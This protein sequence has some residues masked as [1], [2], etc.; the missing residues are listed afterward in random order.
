MADEVAERGAA[1]RD[2]PAES[3]PS[4]VS[5]ED[6]WEI[7][8]A[9]PLPD[10]DRP[11]GPAFVARGVR[12]PRAEAYAV[13]GSDRL[14][15]RSDVLSSLRN[16]ENSALLKPLDNG[17]VDWPKLGRRPVFVFQKPGPPVMRRL[18]E[19]REPMGED[20]VIRQVLQPMLSALKE[21]SDRG[22]VHAQIRPTNMFSQD[23]TGG[24]V[25]LGPCLTE[26]AGYGQ[27]AL[28]ET[29]ERGMAEPIAKGVG[30]V[31]DDL[32]AFGVS[33]LLLILGHNPLAGLDDEALVTAKLERGSY[34]ILV[35]NQRVPT[36]LTEPLRGFLND[37]PRQRWTLNDFD[38]WMNGR[39]LSPK[40]P[41]M[42]KRA[43]RPFEFAGE[44]IFHCRAL[45][46]GL[47]RKPPQ[48]AQAIEAGDIDRWLR[49][50]LGDDVRADQVAQ[51][52]QSASA[53]GRGSTY[54]DRLVARV[55]MAL[56]P[57]A[58][59]R[60]R[61]RR[62]MPTGFGAALAEAMVSGDGVQPLAEMVIGQ[63]PMFWVNVQTDFRAEFVPMVRLFDTMRGWLDKSAPGYGVERVLYDVNPT[64]PCRSPLMGGRDP[65]D[66]GQ[67]LDA[68]ERTAAAPRRPPEPM[69]RHVAAF[70]AARYR[71]IDE[72]L[73]PLL[74][75]GIEPARR[76][77][78]ILLLL[79]EVQRRFGA[80]VH[81]A[82]AAWIADVV[83]PAI[84]R[85]H[86]R[87]TRERTQNALRKAAKLGHL[88]KLVEIV[89]DLEALQRD[90]TGFGLAGRR[91]AAAAAEISRLQ[92]ANN[93]R[94][95]I[96]HDSGRQ[97]G[98]VVSSVLASFILIAAVLHFMGAF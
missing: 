54:E 49:R 74:V 95:R 86:H 53:T 76:T 92:D 26:P 66:L 32:Y 84:L 51:A 39:R 27:P 37:D 47:A 58:P 56:D 14:L 67:M 11:G 55:C 71:K 23:S 83:A 45:A 91:Y 40:Q 25:V 52:V 44:Q 10:Y 1:E 21:L 79:A 19:R 17:L 6:R 77:L 12:D 65:V 24:A 63:L 41:L 98:A 42:P 90:E 35:T 22:I 3:G 33:L 50:S 2:V 81:P 5:L 16:L 94:T 57:D 78:A 96:A 43:I 7:L 29:I 18:D 72:R 9:A 36:A 75:S 60:Y 59:I 31:A 61:G 68:L 20:Q 73:F 70:I 85:F 4:Q 64:M 46:R 48:A 82:L 38:L 8:T 13:I 97:V 93:D 88:S 69:D 62:V 87:P 80:P 15:P 28:F 89:D 30:T 34:G